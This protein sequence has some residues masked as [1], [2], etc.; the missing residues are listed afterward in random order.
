MNKRGYEITAL[1]P[2]K[3]MADFIKKNCRLRLLIVILQKLKTNKKFSLITFNKVL[4]NAE[5]LLT[6]LKKQKNICQ[7]IIV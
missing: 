7:V 1:D 2:D 4:E 5:K 6:F 3:T